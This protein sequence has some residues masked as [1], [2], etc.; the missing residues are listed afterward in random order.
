MHLFL[1]DYIMQLL[2]LQWDSFLIP[3]LR[4]TKMD[5]DCKINYFVLVLHFLSQAFIFPIEKVYTMQALNL[6]P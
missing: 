6:D 3:A 5:E 1:L 4:R 2:K